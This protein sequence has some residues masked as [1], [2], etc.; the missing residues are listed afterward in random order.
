MTKTFTGYVPGLTI[1]P[2]LEEEFF[3]SGVL[4]LSRTPYDRFKVTVTIKYEK[5]RKKKK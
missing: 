3:G 5:L 2:D 4:T 1:V